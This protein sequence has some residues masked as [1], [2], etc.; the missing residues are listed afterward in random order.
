M[1]NPGQLRN[2]IFKLR[3]GAAAALLVTLM[4]VFAGPAFAKTHKDMYS[5]SC[6]ALWPAVKDA[7][8]KSGK[9]GILSIDN[10]EMT[11]SFVIGGHSAASALTPWC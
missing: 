2:L 5:L 7:L 8:R 1:A 3:L 4:L 6:S 10:T 11:S 9:Y